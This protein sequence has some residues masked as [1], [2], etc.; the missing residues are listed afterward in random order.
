M[1]HLLTG[2]DERFSP[3]LLVTASSALL[4]IDSSTPVTIHVMDGG[5]RRQSVDD[6]WSVCLA[7]NPNCEIQIVRVETARFQTFRPGLRN[8]R[9]YY[10][11]LHMGSFLS[12]SRVI[13]LDSDI[14]VLS[15]LAALWRQPMNGKTVLACGDR[16]YAQLG[17][18]C[19]W[20][21]DPGERSLPYFNSG[22]MV[23]DL[24]KWREGNLEEQ[25]LELAAGPT[26]YQWHDQTILNY[27][28]RGRI[29]ILE[30]GLNW[31][32]ESLPS[33]G[34]RD[35]NLHYSTGRKPWSYWGLDARFRIWRAF[36]SAA[37]KSTLGLFLERR[38]ATG[39]A[40]GLLEGTIR[41]R[42]ELRL[43]YLAG[44]LFQRKFAHGQ[45]KAA[46][47]GLYDYY[48]TGLGSPSG[49][50]DVN[51]QDPVITEIMQKLQHPRQ[52]GPANH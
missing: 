21:L 50:R 17:E 14:L 13:Y 15:D 47:D 18:D 4:A 8:S 40:Y 51:P 31:Q 32:Y 12:A 41:R 27:V 45:K 1:I 22:F 24:D 2:A 25:A 42:R 38:E 30:Q 52:S 48:A 6:L 44:I 43:C 28:L 20:P 11:R 10:A 46:L 16:T 39:L 19:P 34:I 26:S 23:V 7:I 9:M 49:D 3:G 33:G 37:D 35:F 36:Y 29:E 5:L